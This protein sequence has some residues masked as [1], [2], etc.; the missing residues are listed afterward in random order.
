V[1]AAV[2]ER[3]GE[4]PRGLQV[5]EPVFVRDGAAFVPTV[6]AR[7]PWDAAALHGGAPAAL[8]AEAVQDPGMIVTRMTFEILGPVPLVPLTVSAAVVKPGRRFQLV[9]AELA[10][11]GRAV[12]RARAVRLRRGAVPLPATDAPA[13]P[14]PPP[15]EPAAPGQA[16]FGVVEG[17][18]FHLSAMDIR[19]V[20]GAFTE[21]GPAAAWFRLVRPLI[22]DDE[23]SPLARAVAAADFGN[24]IG[25]VL[26]W[27][28][29]LFVNPDLTVHVH[30]EPAGEW[31]LLD[32]RTAVEP[33]G[34][35]IAS[36]A[37]HDER[38]PIGRAAQSLYVERS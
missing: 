4:D 25:S 18:G 19:F 2:D 34:V 22:D 1:F 8:L 31:V 6:H 29:Y 17:E 3:P 23:P 5:T 11:A 20:T 15:A 26:D 35:G 27:E 24:G 14:A 32:S 13:P 21:P 36:S 30:R 7:G 38:G 9:E 33:E 37:L 10:A 12:V 16:A 28:R